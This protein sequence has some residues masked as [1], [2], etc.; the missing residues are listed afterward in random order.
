MSISGISTA[1]SGLYQP[2]TSQSPF[3]QDFSQLVGALNSGS[4]SAAQ[5]AYSAL[6]SFA[7]NG[8]GPSSNSPLSQVLSQIGQALQG[9]NLTGAQQA[10]SSLQQ[11]QGGHHHHHGHHHAASDS[12]TASSTSATSTSSTSVPGSLT[13]TSVNV[14]A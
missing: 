2:P 7:S 10:L 14:T 13:G 12:S 4:L 5:Q 6:T 9:N 3:Q 8:Q 11:S 1:Q